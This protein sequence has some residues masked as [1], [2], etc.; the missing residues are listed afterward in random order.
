[1]RHYF[2]K[3]R[4]NEMLLSRI[5]E[6]TEN[7]L[8]NLS[9]HYPYVCVPIFVVMPNHIHAIISIKEQ[10]N[11]ELLSIPTK[12]TVLSVVIGGFK[13]AVTLFA[14][15]NNIDFGW[16]TRYHDHIIRGNRDGNNINRYIENNVTTWDTDCFNTDTL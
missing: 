7:Q 1:M 6:Y 14:R 2:G 11:N 16:Q 3:I 4:N 9:A 8:N 15:R 10:K 5:G 12:R 13:R